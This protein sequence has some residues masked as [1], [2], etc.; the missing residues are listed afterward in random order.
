LWT[1]D[2]ARSATFY[3]TYFGATPG[4]RYANDSKGFESC[5]LSFGDGARLELMKTTTLA[6]SWAPTATETPDGK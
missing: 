6:A 4:V 2:I 5:F 3:V 1:R